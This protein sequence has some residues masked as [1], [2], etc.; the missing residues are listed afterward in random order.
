[1]VRPAPLGTTL[2]SASSDEEDSALVRCLILYETSEGQTAK[3]AGEI[4]ATLRDLGHTVDESRTA[5]APKL[6]DYG[7]VILGSPIHVGE[8]DP[9]LVEWARSHA[10]ELAAVRSAFFSVS[11]AQASKNPQEREEARHMAES[12]VA[13]VG[14]RP[15]LLACFAGAIA[16]SQYGF[17]KKLVMR[18]IAR[19]EG[20]GTDFSQDYEYTDWDQVRS[21]AVQIVESLS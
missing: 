15:D 7:V 4:A 19:K 2:I 10:E 3:I 21:F 13:E 16:Y 12:F 11:L 1:M 20:G 5:D 6:A 9:K 14:W 8:H 18:R 17:L